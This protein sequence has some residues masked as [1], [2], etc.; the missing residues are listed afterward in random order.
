MVEQA[1]AAFARAGGDAADSL[2][3]RLDAAA[4]KVD[5]ARHAA[6]RP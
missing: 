2:E 5:G 4:A 1:R 6:G 3:A